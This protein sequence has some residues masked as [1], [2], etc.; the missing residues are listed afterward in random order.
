LTESLAGQAFQYPEA[1]ITNAACMKM[2]ASE[3][4]RK[5]IM[6]GAI[7]PDFVI[8]GSSSDSCAPLT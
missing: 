3:S 7:P 6:L 1:L 8:S 2:T 5:R 4:P